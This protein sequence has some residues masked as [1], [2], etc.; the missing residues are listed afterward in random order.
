MK[1]VSLVINES[2]LPFVLAAIRNHSNS[3]IKNLCSQALPEIDTLTV[4]K[5]PTVNIATKAPRLSK[6]GKRMG[7]PPKGAK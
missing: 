2:D 7:R 5:T 1:T 3:L 4:Q 6:N